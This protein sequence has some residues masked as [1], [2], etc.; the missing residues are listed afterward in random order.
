MLAIIGGS[1]A[2]FAPYTDLYQHADEQFGTTAY[3]VGVYSLGFITDSGGLAKETSYSAYKQMRDRIGA[4]RGWAP[5]TRSE[6]EHEAQYGALHIGSP[7]TVARKIAGTIRSLDAGRFDLI[8][9]GGAVSASA[10]LRSV[11]LYGTKVIPMVRELLS[12][13]PATEGK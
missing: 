6:F 7:E 11:E 13:K 12:E 4:E 10:R 9:S 5:M 2:R 8:Y 1:P 3:P